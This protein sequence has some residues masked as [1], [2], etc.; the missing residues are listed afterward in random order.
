MGLNNFMTD[1]SEFISVVPQIQRSPNV[2]PV[3]NFFKH[4]PYFCNSHSY[5]HIYKKK[6]FVSNCSKGYIEHWYGI[7]TLNPENFLEFL[8]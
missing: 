1:F 5:S 3:V 2:R 6:N 4:I 8:V 7:R